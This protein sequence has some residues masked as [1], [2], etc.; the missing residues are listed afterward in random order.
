MSA[1]QNF[2][3]FLLKV[4]NYTDDQDEIATKISIKQFVDGS[5]DFKQF[6]KT[7]ET[8]SATQIDKHEDMQYLHDYAGWLKTDLTPEGL[9]ELK[10]LLEQAIAPVKYEKLEDDSVLEVTGNNLVMSKV[11]K[12]VEQDP[13]FVGGGVKEVRIVARSI[14]HADVNLEQEKWHGKNFVVW[15][16]ELNVTKENSVWNFSGYDQNNKFL[17]SADTDKDGNGLDGKD[18]EPGEDI[19]L[20]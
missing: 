9:D 17:E 2:V 5:I 7:V 4:V 20:F 19:N 11:I 12:Q 15:T 16:N 14:L 18:G 8:Y 13:G 1:V 6:V 3:D 10:K